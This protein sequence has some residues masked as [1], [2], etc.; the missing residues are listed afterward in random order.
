[1]T[2]IE[3]VIQMVNYT[4]VNESL[5]VIA[6]DISDKT[7]AGIL[8]SPKQIQ[9]D[10]DKLNKMPLT[11]VAISSCECCSSMVTCK[12]C[13][14]VSVGDKIFVRGQLLELPIELPLLDGKK[15][16]LFQVR[17]YDVLG[18]VTNE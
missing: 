12:K 1:M 11:V 18:K 4:P 2:T 14:P 3:D 7:D 16:L 17:N 15:Y 9:E 13:P 8:K 6:P 5:V 10:R